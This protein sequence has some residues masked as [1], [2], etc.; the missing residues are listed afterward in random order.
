MF[1]SEKAHFYYFLTNVLKKY[2]SEQLILTNW[3]VIDW[4]SH[5]FLLCL[6]LWS[7]AHLG[8]WKNLSGDDQKG[9]IQ[10]TILFCNGNQ[11]SFLVKKMKNTSV[12]EFSDEINTGQ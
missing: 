10:I 7:F 6:A 4:S 5:E 12:A 1:A 9:W 11:K 2:W 3:Y 8:T